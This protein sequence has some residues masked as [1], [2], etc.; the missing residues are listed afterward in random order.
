MSLVLWIHISFSPVFTNK[1]DLHAE[2]AADQLLRIL[3][4]V[5]LATNAQNKPM[6]L[7]TVLGVVVCFTCGVIKGK[8]VL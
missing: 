5:E 6:T 2:F 8:K 7:C 3:D 4:C 1:I